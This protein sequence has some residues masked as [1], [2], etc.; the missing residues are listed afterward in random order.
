M[1]W[2]ESSNSRNDNVNSLEQRI[3]MVYIVISI[4][5]VTKYFCNLYVQAVHLRKKL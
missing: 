4:F 5:I 3:F 2:T 1:N